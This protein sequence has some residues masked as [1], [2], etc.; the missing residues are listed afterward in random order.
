MKFK[1]C[2]KNDALALFR[3]SVGKLL[4]I[5]NLNVINKVLYII[6]YVEIY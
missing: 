2:S 6:F 5:L 1:M 4:K 3:V